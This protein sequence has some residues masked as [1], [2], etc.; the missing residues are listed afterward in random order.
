MS[1]DKWIDEDVVCIYNEIT[2]S[3]KKKEF[4]LVLVWWMKL[5]FVIQRERVIQSEREKQISYLN[6]YIWNLERWYWWTCLQ[7]RNGDPDVENRL[8]NTV[9]EGKSG[10]NGETSINIYTWSYV[11]WIAGEELLCYTGSPVWLSVRTWK[12]E[13]GERRKAQR[14]EISV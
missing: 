3:H 7:G 8:V 14:E 6:A 4:E 5:E 11:K 12:S 1:I 10:M 9:R 2:L 13:M